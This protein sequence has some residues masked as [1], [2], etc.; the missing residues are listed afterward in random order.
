[1]ETYRMD[2]AKI[3]TLE[4]GK[5]ISESLGEISYAISFYEL[6]AEEAKRITGDIISSPVKGRK[7]LAIKQPVGPAALITRSSLQLTSID[8]EVLLFLLV[9]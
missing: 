3:M 8:D 5:P 2:L 4:S 7:L 9:V 1:M 6:Y